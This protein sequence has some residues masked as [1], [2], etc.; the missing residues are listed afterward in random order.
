MPINVKE[1]DHIWFSYTGTPGHTCMSEPQV[2]V[3]G[4]IVLISLLPNFQEATYNRAGVVLPR[5]GTGT[6][7]IDGH[8][9]VARVESIHG[10]LYVVE[11]EQGVTPGK[12]ELSARL[13][14]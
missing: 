4:N 2:S 11:I 9:F 1:I 12:F 10:W 5:D 8:R 13:M 6:L 7:F 3:P 14:S